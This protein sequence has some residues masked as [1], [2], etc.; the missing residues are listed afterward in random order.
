MERG[1]SV[2]RKL[3][4]EDMQEIRILKPNLYTHKPQQKLYKNKKPKWQD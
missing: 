1:G 2:E 3:L 4:E